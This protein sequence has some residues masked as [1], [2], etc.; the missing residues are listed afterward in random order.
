VVTRWDA[1]TERTEVEVAHEALIRSWEV[2]RGWLDEDREV[3]RQREGV[4]RAAVDWEQNE[5]DPAY[6]VH[7]GRRLD[8]AEALLRHPRVALNAGERAYVEACLALRVKGAI[9]ELRDAMVR[10]EPAGHWLDRLRDGGQ[11]LI[12]QLEEPSVPGPGRQADPSALDQ[13][14]APLGLSDVTLPEWTGE[15][16][17]SFGPVAWSAVSHQDPGTRQTAALALTVPYDS[18]AL[19]RLIKALDAWGGQAHPGRWQQRWRRAEVWGSLGNACPALEE[20]IKQSANLSLA[21]RASVWLWRRLMRDRERILALTLGGAVGAGVGLAL[22]RGLTALATGLT[23]PLQSILGFW[24]G[25]LLGAG[26]TFGLLLPQAGSRERGADGEGAAAPRVRPSAEWRAV[27]VGTL[28]FGL[29]HLFIGAVTGYLRLEAMVL[30][31]LAGLLMGLGISLGFYGWSWSEGETRSWR[32]LLRLLPVV[33]GALLGQMVVYLAGREWPTAVGF[34]GSL[35]RS[36]L[37]RFGGAWWHGL[38]TETYRA[39]GLLDAVLVAVALF[40]GIAAGGRLAHRW[41]R[42][43]R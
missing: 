11:A 12:Q 19:E 36:E 21:D 5:R 7:H 9:L 35:Y 20:S 38:V 17:P 6:L 26:L 18:R 34:S 14:R 4:R 27:I 15:G 16:E 1:I 8:K 41:L 10:R 3:L 29:V 40:V 39:F 28:G 33:V 23:A 22:L 32:W 31:N 37:S 24:W 25:L 13:I 2:L 42:R 43:L 30:V